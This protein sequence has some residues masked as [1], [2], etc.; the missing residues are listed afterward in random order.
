MYVTYVYFYV[1][2]YASMYVS[3][4]LCMH[5]LPIYVFDKR[6]PLGCLSREEKNCDVFASQ[7]LM[8]YIRTYVRMCVCLSVCV[9][10]H[11]MCCVCVCLCV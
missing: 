6:G 8:K 5:A 10:V 3:I 2:M 7:K 1:C 4:Y 9:C 11:Y